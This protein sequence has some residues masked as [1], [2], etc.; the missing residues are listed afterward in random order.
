MRQRSQWTCSARCCQATKGVGTRKSCRRR[1]IIRRG[2]R[3]SLFKFLS[4]Q[5]FYV[6]HLIGERG[7]RRRQN[8]HFWQS[9]YVLKLNLLIMGRKNSIFQKKIK[10]KN[11]NK[12]KTK[13]KTKNSRY[14]KFCTSIARAV[15][16]QRQNSFFSLKV[17][18]NKQ[19]LLGVDSSRRRGKIYIFLLFL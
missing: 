12:N 8:S 17:S 10:N 5:F 14:T 13:N 4:S 7:Q 1:R 2:F 16:N 19:W 9:W 18:L 3:C 6:K 11:K 15:S